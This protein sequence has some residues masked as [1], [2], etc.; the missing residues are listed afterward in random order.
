MDHRDWHIL[1]GNMRNLPQYGLSYWTYY[2][3]TFDG[4]II[5]GNLFDLL[6]YRSIWQT[7]HRQKSVE[8]AM[9][10]EWWMALPQAE[11]YWTSHALTVW[12][13]NSFLLDRNLMDP[14][15]VGFDDLTELLYSVKVYIYYAF[16]NLLQLG[17]LHLYID[18]MMDKL[19]NIFIV[20]NYRWWRRDKQ[21]IMR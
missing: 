4:P 21:A 18:L 10:F 11:I 3:M 2:D 16:L 14:Q 9:R 5:R 12:W 15:W 13:T 8:P 1:R 7:Y 6:W 17:W 19:C 20:S